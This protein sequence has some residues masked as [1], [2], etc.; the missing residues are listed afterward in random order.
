MSEL[1]NMALGAGGMKE[2]I[3]HLYISQ[4][5]FSEICPQVADLKTDWDDNASRI[6]TAITL[7]IPPDHHVRD[8]VK[9]GDHALIEI[10]GPECPIVPPA[11]SGLM[12]VGLIDLEYTH[13]QP[14]AKIRIVREAETRERP[15][16]VEVNFTTETEIK[17]EFSKDEGSCV[18]LDEAAKAWGETSLKELLGSSEKF[19]VIESNFIYHES[20]QKEVEDGFDS[21]IAAMQQMTD[22]GPNPI[23]EQA[24]QF[25]ERGALPDPVV[26]A[27]DQGKVKHPECSLEVIRMCHAYAKAFDM[28]FDHYDSHS[29]NAKFSYPDSDA[30]TKR[31]IYLVMDWHKGAKKEHL[32]AIKTVDEEGRVTV[33]MPPRHGKTQSM[34]HPR[35]KSPNCRCSFELVKEETVRTLSGTRTV[36]TWSPV[37]CTHGT[38]S[39]RITE[40]REDPA[41][42]EPI[43][44]YERRVMEDEAKKYDSQPLLNIDGSWKA[45]QFG[46]M[47]CRDMVRDDQSGK[48]T[49][50]GFTLVDRERFAI[51]TDGYFTAARVLD[52]GHT[53]RRRLISD[54]YMI[55]V[56]NSRGQRIGHFAID[57]TFDKNKITG[58]L[59]GISPEEFR[60]MQDGVYHLVSV[61]AHENTP[62]NPEIIGCNLLEE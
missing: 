17:F 14:Y 10:E 54:R 33:R 46:S 48:F 1:L 31:S 29:G 9:R 58:S 32:R 2:R 15:A 41:T 39:E 59:V 11:G 20:T 30:R 52:M 55:P 21:N 51:R 26:P 25:A 60:R 7:K 18:P 13:G 24:R 38:A 4:R 35:M 56:S 53:L 37:N 12:R 27:D 44:E 47:I 43:K 40:E 49:L 50:M 62:D 57:E 3:G 22:G 34:S 16:F 6:A 5:V 42:P 45:P 19:K 36:K 8:V 23:A 61:E 28:R